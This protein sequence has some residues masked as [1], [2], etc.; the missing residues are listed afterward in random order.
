MNSLSRG[1]LAARTPTPTGVC[2]AKPTES[3]GWGTIY[4]G[5][6][7]MRCTHTT[8]IPPGTQRCK[9]DGGCPFRLPRGGPQ[10]CWWHRDTEV[11]AADY[12]DWGGPA[13]LTGNWSTR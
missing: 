11:V 6:D 13:P 12:A 7:H 1:H 10:F 4:R 5:A 3:N 9:G 2:H 8:P